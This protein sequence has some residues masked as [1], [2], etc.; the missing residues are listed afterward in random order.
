MHWFFRTS[1]FASLGLMLWTF[2]AYASEQHKHEH[3]TVT[4]NVAIDGNVL[5]L[6]IEA[7][8][9]NVLGFEKSPRTDAER[10]TVATVDAWLSAGREIAGVPRSAGCRAQSV[11]YEAP[12][13]GSGHADYRP[14]FVFRCGNP[15]ALEWVELWALRRFKD[16]EKAKVN[17]ISASMQRQETLAPGRLR[18]SLK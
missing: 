8:A 15:A 4:F 17:V 10:Q 12:K 2:P 5:S 14:R 3:G 6:E 11:I 9:I 7:P 1:F 13:L 18:V 16:V